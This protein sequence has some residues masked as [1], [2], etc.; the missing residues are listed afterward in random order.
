MPTATL[1]LPLPPTHPHPPVCPSCAA[2]CMGVSSRQPIFS[3]KF[4]PGLSCTGT[5]APW[6][7]G[8]V[9]AEVLYTSR[10]EPSRTIKEGTLET[11]C[12]RR[13]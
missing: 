13:R 9:E 7:M 3:L 1:M 6:S 12:K 8:R 11:A 4:K 10:H 5:P 2:T